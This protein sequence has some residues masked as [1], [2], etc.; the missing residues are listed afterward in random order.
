MHEA[1]E[2]VPW[3]STSFVAGISA[4]KLVNQRRQITISLAEPSG[5]RHP[6]LALGQLENLWVF[7]FKQIIVST[8]DFQVQSTGFPSISL[9]LLFSDSTTMAKLVS[10]TKCNKSCKFLLT[11]GFK[12]C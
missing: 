9:E 8:L 3:A 6:T 7:F 2:N 1:V 12:N 11:A 10:Y 4:T 5:H